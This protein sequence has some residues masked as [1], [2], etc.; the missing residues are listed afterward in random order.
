MDGQRVKEW[1]ARCIEEQP[2]AC[3]TACPLRVD[4]RGMLAKMKT[5]DFAGACRP[6]RPRHPFSRHP[7][8]DLRSPLRGGLPQS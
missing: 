2:P 8:P 4:V 7:Q 6:I 1:E 3:T 5:G